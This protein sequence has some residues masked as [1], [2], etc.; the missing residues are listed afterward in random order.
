MF[1][2][3]SS[4]LPSFSSLLLFLIYSSSTFMKIHSFTLSEIFSV[5]LAAQLRDEMGTGRQYPQGQTKSLHSDLSRPPSPLRVA[6]LANQSRRD[7]LSTSQTGNLCKQY[8][9]KWRTPD[10]RIPWLWVFFLLFGLCPSVGSTNTPWGQIL[11]RVFL[12]HK[13]EVNI[14]RSKSPKETEKPQH[15]IF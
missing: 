12:F 14:H 13:P 5:I 2:F 8:T 1:C 4:F 9:S 3:S 15:L 10:C 11:R 7:M 6:V